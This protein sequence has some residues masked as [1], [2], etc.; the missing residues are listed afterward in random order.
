MAWH[1][2]VWKQGRHAALLHLE[3]GKEKRQDSRLLR[4]ENQSCPRW[5]SASPGGEG[6]HYYYYCYYF[7]N[8]YRGT[9]HRICFFPM[10]GILVLPWGEGE[11]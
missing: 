4:D 1:G 5:A 7:Y 11:N 6:V 2:M 9:S 8:F 3:D 10:D